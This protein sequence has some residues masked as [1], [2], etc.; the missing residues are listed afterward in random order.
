MRDIH[1]PVW[2]GSASL[3][4]AVVFAT[5]F[6]LEA[7]SRTIL[8]AVIPLQALRLLGDA[9]N[10]STAYFLA[11]IA[12]LLGSF[13]I[14]WLVRKI[15]RR[16]VMTAGALSGV[17][18]AFAFSIQDPAALLA[19]LVLQA[20]ANASLGIVLNLYVMDHIA[21]REM[22]RFEPFRMFLSASA[23]AVGPFLGV[24]LSA[25]VSLYA[26]YV[27]SAGACLTMLSFFWYLRITD[28]PAVASRPLRS[29]NPLRYLPRFFSQKRLALS[30]ILAFGRSGWWQ[31]FFVYAPIYAVTNGFDEVTGGAIVS[32][33]ST[34]LYLVPLWGWVGRRFGLRR[35]MIAGYTGAGLTTMAIALTTGLPWVGA[36][37][38]VGAAL[39]ASL[40]DGAGN[41]PF[42]RAVRPFERAEMTTVFMTFRNASQ[43]GP[44]G[45][46]AFLLRTWELP[47]VFL[48]GGL[49]TL[50]MAALSGFIHRRM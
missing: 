14:P 19:G 43:F 26:C 17:V 3:S 24:W 9:Q 28:N 31:L 15:R 49:M 45:L 36:G 22:N 16:T 25:H 42:L 44:P 8:L 34:S 46:Y 5:L 33:G 29:P 20:F 1:M 39:M 18:G 11:G 23:W 13:A 38:I 50:S 27:L 4:R 30:W 37:L 47:A 32:V 35:L 48:A 7:F 21:R 2:L 12:G 41:V 40:V 6:F 10:V